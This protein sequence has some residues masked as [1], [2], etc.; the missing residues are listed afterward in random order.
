MECLKH[1]GFISAKKTFSQLLLE[2]NSLLKE[3]LIVS[4]NCCQ[5]IEWQRNSCPFAMRYN[6]INKNNNNETK[7]PT[8]PPH[9]TN[10]SF[11]YFMYQLFWSVCVGNIMMY[12][13]SATKFSQTKTCYT[14]TNAHYQNMTTIMTK[15]S[16]KDLSNSLTPKIYPYAPARRDPLKVAVKL[17]WQS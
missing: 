9:N 14:L 10:K 8:E 12:K 6:N 15:S 2:K 13:Y 7:N 3:S 16:P 4:L 5:I 1:Q 11:P 17:H